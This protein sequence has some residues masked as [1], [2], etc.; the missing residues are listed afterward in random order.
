M[1]SLGNPKTWVPYTN[2][3]DCSQGLC[4]LYCPQWCY[5]IFPPPPFEFPNENSTPNLSPLV[6]AII[7]ILASAFL[8]VSYYAIISKFCSNN[9]STRENNH[10]PNVE[11]DENRDPSNHE[12]WH[13]PT[14]GLD[15]A[16]IKSIKT[17]KFKKGD[18][19]LIQDC[20]VCLSEFEEDESL[21]FLPKCNHLFHVKCIDTWLRSHSNCPLCRTSVG[22]VNALEPNVER[23]D[24]FTALE[25]METHSEGE[26]SRVGSLVEEGDAIIE[27]TDEEEEE[28]RCTHPPFTPL[29]PALSVGYMGQTRVSMMD[30]LRIDCRDEGGSSKRQNLGMMGKCSSHRS[31]VLHCVMKSPVSMKRS[32]SSGRFSLAAR[33]RGG[34]NIVIPL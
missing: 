11:L 32:F 24:H 12:P 19:T 1:G 16:I 27:I 7:G 22:F 5:R 20:P 28:N 8:L 33:R 4:S 2:T 13:G 18:S 14:N 34:R 9:S 26:T 23:N 6:I 10:T 29:G 15:E 25:A 21:R 31:Q 17:C 30:V 3:K